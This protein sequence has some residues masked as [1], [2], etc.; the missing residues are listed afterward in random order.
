MDKNKE[1]KLRNITKED[2]QQIL[3][4]HEK[5]LDPN[6]K[7]GRRANLRNA[8]LK[9]FDFRNK[10]LKKA[11]FEGANLKGARFDDAD[12]QHARLVYTDCQ[13]TNFQNANLQNANFQNANLSGADVT[14]A[15]LSHSTFQDTDCTV[16]KGLSKARL[17]YADLSGAKGLLETEFAGKDLTGTKLPENLHEFKSLQII[18]ETSK[19]ARNIFFAML[20]GCVYSLLTVATTTDVAL[21]TN[22]A[23]SPLPI[24]GTEIPIAWFY[25]VAP[26]VL[27]CLYLYLH[28]Y[29]YNLWKDLADLPAIFPDGNSLERIVYPWLLTCIVCRHVELL[30]GRSYMAHMKEWITI[31]L[32]WWAVPLTF[33]VFWLRYLLRHEWRGTL[34]HI[35]LINFSFI[36]AFLFYGVAAHVLRRKRDN[37]SSSQFAR[38]SERI[39]FVIVSSAI[40]IAIFGI[41]SHA[42]IHGTRSQLIEVGVRQ[43]PNFYMLL[44]LAM[45]KI[46]FCPFANF[47]EKDVSTKP[48]DYYRITD[49]E[50]LIHSV[51]GANLKNR[52]LTF[53]DM[54]KAF[55]VIADLRSANLQNANLRNANL[56]N[57]DFR[58][59]NLQNVNLQNA[60]LQNADLRRTNLQNAVLKEAKLQH[61]NLMDANLPFIDLEEAN[62]QKARI[63]NANLL[64]ADLYGADLREADLEDADLREAYLGGANL[65]KAIL[66]GASLIDANLNDANL[67]ETDLSY[68][69]LQKAWLSGVNLQKAKFESADL[70]YAVM[71]GT[72]LRYTDLSGCKNLTQEQL[73]YSCGNEAT[74]L[75]EG[76]TIK[77]CV[78]EKNDN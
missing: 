6:N 17:I 30:K 35:G 61:A 9:K 20:L 14:K 29:L 55:L 53:A 34:L 31:F 62:L 46:G 72:D 2:I 37:S 68:A 26:F 42:A 67:Q 25:W 3:E 43:P 24:I 75:P 47:Q 71:S 32:A 22:T 8:N 66:V 7:D 33:V 64:R 10:N 1:S 74:K 36:L 52:N 5:W 21:L 45:E 4:D 28:F 27:L 48:E 15:N 65:Q 40:V 76:L 51:K 73:H 58:N 49:D 59:A 54:Q 11:N 38:R 69:N 39:G 18:E 41:F 77:N 56:Q 19:N 63:V 78:E 60:V 70:Q 16:V 13:N 23:S 44:P 57:A 12:L 50:K